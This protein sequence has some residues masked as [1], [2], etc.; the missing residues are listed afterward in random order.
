MGDA[1]FLNLEMYTGEVTEVEGGICDLK[2]T[3]NIFP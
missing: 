1:I 3:E 2:T